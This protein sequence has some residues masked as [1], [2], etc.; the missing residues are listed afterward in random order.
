[1]IDSL[2]TDGELWNQAFAYLK[3]EVSNDDLHGPRIST[4]LYMLIRTSINC[5]WGDYLISNPICKAEQEYKSVWTNSC[6][7]VL[8]S[9]KWR[10]L[11]TT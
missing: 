9:T 4:Q 10:D 2:R 11:W 7:V 3:E 8:T 5:W 1:M 6:S